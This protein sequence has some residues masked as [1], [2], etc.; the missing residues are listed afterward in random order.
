MGET[1]PQSNAADL[2]DDVRCMICGYNLRGLP[3]R[4]ACPECGGEVADSCQGDLLKYADP[5]WVMCIYKGALFIGAA[6]GF[7][8][9]YFVVG[10]MVFAAVQIAGLQIDGWA[11]IAPYLFFTVLT[12]SVAMALLGVFLITAQEPREYLVEDLAATRRLARAAILVGVLLFIF[13]YYIMPGFYSV[14]MGVLINL[15]FVISLALSLSHAQR[16]VRRIPD[17]RLCGLLQ[18][19][20]RV[21]LTVGL[22]F[23][24]ALMLLFIS[25]AATQS[26]WSTAAFVLTM[27]LCCVYVVVA[28]VSVG[29]FVAVAAALKGAR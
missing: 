18:R 13:K 27:A 10:G 11:R 28:I 17:H 21:L 5:K 9:T 20:R 8:F 23:S 2:Q 15:A 24:G 1:P 12:A 25:R 4:G 22:C 3:V 7:F 19:C 16:V 29:L 26:W 14:L 6:F